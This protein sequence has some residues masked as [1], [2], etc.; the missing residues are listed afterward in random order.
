MSRKKL[1]Y[2]FLFATVYVSGLCVPVYGEPLKVKIIQPDQVKENQILYNGKLWHNLYSYI[3]GDQFLFTKDFLAGSVTM[4]GQSFKGVDLIYD[5]YNDEIITITNHGFYVQLNKEMV[6][7]FT[8][9]FEN[10]TYRFLNTQ[11]DTIKG[12]KGYVNVLYKGKSALYVKY[13]K[14]I[15]LLAVDEK[16]D[17]FYQT[18]KIYLVKDGVIYQLSGKRDLLKIL[19]EDKTKIREFMKKN[20]FGVTK[21]IPESFIPVIR[22]YDSISNRPV[23]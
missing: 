9:T 22:Y 1:L 19:Q 4:N 18:Y 14:E 7:S 5:I 10:K 2:I 11:T 21:K 12:I 23:L 6:D 13:K 16:Y 15:E 20:K 3:K 8:L 17:L